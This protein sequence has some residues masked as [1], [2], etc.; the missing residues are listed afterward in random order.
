MN[1]RQSLRGGSLVLAVFCAVNDRCGATEYGT[2]ALVN[3]SSN[4]ICAQVRY[5]GGEWGRL[6]YNGNNYIGSTKTGSGAWTTHVAGTTY[7]LRI[8]TNSTGITGGYV[9]FDS[10]VCPVGG[11]AKNWAYPVVGPQLYTN[12]FVAMNFTNKQA[13]Y[14]E[15]GFDVLSNNVF[16]LHTNVL[17]APGGSFYWGA[18]NYNVQ[19]NAFRMTVTSWTGDVRSNDGGFYTYTWVLTNEQGS[20]RN[21]TTFTNK[22][23]DTIYWGWTN[24][25]L[26]LP[27]LASA[28][29]TNDYSTAAAIAASQ[30]FND[31]MREQETRT[32]QANIANEDRR[33]AN[34]LYDQA[35][36]AANLAHEDALKAQAQAQLSLQTLTNRM[37]DFSAAQISAAR[38]DASN[39]LAAAQTRLVAY[40]N[41]MG[42]LSQL[43]VAESLRASS[44]AAVKT[45]WQTMLF[46]NAL[47]EIKAGLVTGD[48]NASNR[49]AG[50]EALLRD[51]GAGQSNLTAN[52]LQSLGR[53]SE[54]DRGIDEVRVATQEG[55]SNVVTAV[56][57]ASTNNYSPGTINT[58]FIVSDWSLTNVPSVVFNNAAAEAV[59]RSAVPLPGPLGMEAPV[60]A[61]PLGSL[62][63]AGLYHHFSFQS[64]PHLR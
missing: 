3:N 23:T 45:D 54:I 19:S 6:A 4:T 16:L 32:L 41:L 9:E 25:N 30:K 48:V 15:Y 8:Y 43:Q 47:G 12:T 2:Y 59:L 37:A 64:H 63:V 20:L 24:P 50:L 5:P 21:V 33:A 60:I 28:G 34:A 18:T 51:T 22:Q 52:V 40:T 10:W 29:R 57:E 44:N 11:F 55:L 49:M 14:G 46:T 53:L 7:S 61:I 17:L 35:A 1:V 31:D 36:Q 39:A 27:N 62:G 58:N 42:V 13:L 56:R 38:S 26:T